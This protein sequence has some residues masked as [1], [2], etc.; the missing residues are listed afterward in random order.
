[1][2]SL[3]SVAFALSFSRVYWTEEEGIV[4]RTASPFIERQLCY[5]IT[6]TNMKEDDINYAKWRIHR[7]P[8][9][10]QSACLESLACRLLPVPLG[11]IHAPL[12]KVMGG[13]L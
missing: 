4:P 3:P 2:S 12:F 10:S 9:D 5:Y 7:V 11:I 6:C 13:G 8:A 1:M